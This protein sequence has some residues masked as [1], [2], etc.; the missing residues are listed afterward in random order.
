MVSVSFQV[1]WEGGNGGP[2]YPPALGHTVI[3]SALGSETCK[4]N[5]AVLGAIEKVKEFLRDDRG[6]GVGSDTT[7]VLQVLWG[8]VLVMFMVLK[9]GCTGGCMHQPFAQGVAGHLL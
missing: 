8:A 3:H 7:D 4:G 1:V 2:L 6:G 9:K 5:D